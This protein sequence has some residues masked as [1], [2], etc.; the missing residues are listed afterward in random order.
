MTEPKLCKDCRWA[1]TRAADL[2]MQR[3]YDWE[4]RHSSSLM[5][6]SPPSRVTGEIRPAWH[7]D[8]Q[9]ARSWET[10]PRTKQVYC[11]DEARY[12]EP[13]GFGT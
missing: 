1:V 8:C 2:S 3:V 11:G 10:D 7:L 9:T 4:C 6:A 5:P 13:I 12:W